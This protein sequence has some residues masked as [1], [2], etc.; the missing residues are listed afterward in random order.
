MSNTETQPLKIGMLIYPDIT[1][2]D[3]VGAHAVLGI[4]GQTFLLSK[5]MDPVMADTKVSINPTTLLADCPKDLDVLFVPGGYGAAAA[6]EDDEI[7]EFLA[8]AGK[9]A[10]YI[11]G[12]CNGTPLLGAAGLLTGYKAATHWSSYGA[13]AE[14]GAIPVHERVVIDRNRVTAGGVTS[15]IDFGIT[16]LA[17]LRGDEIA[18]ATQL[19]LE[20]N[21]EPPFDTGTPERA[22]PEITAMANTIF[23]LPTV[24]AN[25]ISAIKSR[26]ARRSKKSA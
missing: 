13:L 16:L 14:T 17:K 18:K 15:G 4:H 12:V 7:V 24:D 26:A 21:P 25:Q 2:Q 9:T 8:E 6:L 3:L 23:S 1:L 19:L 22:G 11:T 20:Y 10:K 5:T